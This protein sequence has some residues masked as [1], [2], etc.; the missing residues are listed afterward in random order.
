MKAFLFLLSRYGICRDPRIKYHLLY[1]GYKIFMSISVN[2]EIKIFGVIKDAE[3]AWDGQ[4]FAKRCASSLFGHLKI[5]QISKKQNAY[6]GIRTRDVYLETYKDL[7]YAIKSLVSGQ[8]NQFIKSV[9]MTET[10]IY[11]TIYDKFILSRTLKIC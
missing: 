11:F 9:D 6:T 8:F 3:N 7:H 4:I 1:W 10:V 5:I 2:D